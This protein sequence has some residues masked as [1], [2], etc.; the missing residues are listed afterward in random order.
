MG[1][2]FIPAGGLTSTPGAAGTMLPKTGT[3]D[4]NLRQ[5]PCDHQQHLERYQ[6][7]L[8]DLRTLNL[9]AEPSINMRGPIN[10]IALVQVYIGG[11]LVQPDDPTYG[12]QVLPDPNRVQFGGNPE[13][14]YKIVFNQEVRMVRQLIEV[15]YL[16][17]QA[18]CL[19]CN[20]NGV[21]NDFK[22]AS[23]GSFI[24]VVNT[25]KL[26]QRVLK[27]VLTSRCVFYPQFTCPIKD[28]IGRKFGVTITDAEI[29]QA[30]MTALINLK[31]IQIGQNA[32]QPLSPSETL[33]DITNVTAV[34][35]AQDPTI[36]HVSASIVSY[37]NQAQNNLVTTP[38]QFSL[39]VNS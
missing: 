28:F 26:V 12:Y 2:T 10:G 38:V 13:K 21:L 32:V 5:A 33:K 14:F 27:F 29:A 3:Y 4:F 31:Q 7:N 23:S 22:I 30:V 34:Q 8:S 19:K 35:D 24:R 36:V 39:Q 1:L 9:V 20:G 16:T 17:R 11:E 15:N 18:F 6:V 25:D 37:T